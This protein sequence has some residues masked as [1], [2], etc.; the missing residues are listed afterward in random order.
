MWVRKRLLRRALAGLGSVLVGAAVAA[1]F[2]PSFREF[3]GDSDLGLLLYAAVPP[4]VLA[5]DK[6]WRDRNA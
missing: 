5:I 6:W 2:S 3:C 4:V 1:A